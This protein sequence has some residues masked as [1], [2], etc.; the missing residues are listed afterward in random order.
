[1]RRRLANALQWYQVMVLRAQATVSER[2][3]VADIV[4]GTVPATSPS[5]PTSVSLTPTPS[6]LTSSPAVSVLP[7]SAPD[8][9]A[10]APCLPTL[11]TPATFGSPASSPSPVSPL[12]PNHQP[13]SSSHKTPNT[14]R[15][16]AYLRACCPLC[17]AGPKPDLKQSL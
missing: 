4:D 7:S 15:P 13:S 14:D 6:T 17:F 1:M 12:N 11:P 5:H 16:S 9:S 3:Y 10:P 2:I 8:T